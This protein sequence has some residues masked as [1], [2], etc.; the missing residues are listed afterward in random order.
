MRFDKCVSCSRT[1]GWVGL[2]TNLV[3]MVMKGFVGLVSGSQAMVVDTMYSAKDVVTSLLVIVGMAVSD[4]PL[5]EKHP[6]GHGKIEFVLSLIISVIFLLITGYLL[7]HAIQILLDP[8]RHRTPHLIA[9]W[10]AVVAVGVNVFMYAYAR[11]V[12]IEINSPMVRTL[13]KHSHSDAVASGV[14]AVGIV[15]AH[16]LGM[17]WLDPVIAIFETLDLLYLGGGVFWDAYKGL[18][19]RS[20]GISLLDKVQPLATAVSGVIEVKQLRSRHVGQEIWIDLVVGVD[21]GLSVEQAHAICEA[22]KAR[23]SA[24][25]SHIGAM[26]VSAE[27][28]HEG[29]A[30]PATPIVPTRPQALTETDDLVA[31]LE[32]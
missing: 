8:E 11:C 31:E 23:I 20:V 15:G 25:I 12:A 28:Q 5:D 9:L 2:T 21:G 18:M 17:S 22:V 6:Y 10:A 16:Y 29:A 30:A 27:S 26:N 19:D 4:K 14:V 24:N 7:V 1:I 3:L 32:S 13:A